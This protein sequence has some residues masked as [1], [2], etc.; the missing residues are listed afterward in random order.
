MN[1]STSLEYLNPGVMNS[2]T[3]SHVA[4]I[5]LTKLAILTVYEHTSSN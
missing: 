1:P 4:S 2:P 5:Q 3:S